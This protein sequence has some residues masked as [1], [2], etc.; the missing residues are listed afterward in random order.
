M[1]HMGKSQATLRIIGETLVPDEISA[2]L[3]CQ[4][5]ASQTKGL[6]TET[7][8]THRV[9]MW[10]LSA[11]EAIPE[12]LDGQTAELL[13]MMSSDLAV[14]ASISNNYRI[15]LF[16]GLFMERTTRGW[17]LRPRR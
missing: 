13:S 4:P 3:G 9:G 12:N 16:C 7:G 11:T 5:S 15:G 14:W 8:R 2:L 1:A 17:Y 10:R 6:R